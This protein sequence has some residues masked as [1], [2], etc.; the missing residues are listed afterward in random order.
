M[1][2]ALLLCLC[3]PAQ[4]LPANFREA[5]PR[6]YSGAQP[7]AAYFPALY[8]R[9]IR[10]ILSVDGARPDV[11]AAREAGLV[12]VHIPI[13]YD[14]ITNEEA[15][16]LSRVL[17]ERS[18]DIFIH[19]HHG[20][21]RGPAMA[22]LG[23]RLVAP[24][25]SPAEALDFLERAGTSKEYAGLWQDVEACN[26]EAIALL[27]PQ[28]HEVFPTSNIVEAMVSIDHHFH[29]LDQLIK[30]QL[31]PLA[32]AP[33]LV[34]ALEAR[35]LAQQLEAAPMHEDNDAEYDTFMNGCTSRAKELEVVIESRDVRRCAE[36]FEALRQDCRQCHV[37]FRN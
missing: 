17:R 2:L 5:A 16:V 36:V 3:A 12:Y 32:E 37:K 20:I 31:K 1:L 13:G 35:I 33:D 26:P 11:D 34:A 29:H 21:H 15:A 19:C 28:L 4:E 7:D 22:A 23:M 27:Q 6:I 8:A 9:G 30:N 24:P 25:S 18:G 14:G 10:T